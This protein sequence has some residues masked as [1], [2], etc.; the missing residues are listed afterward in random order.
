[1][2]NLIIGFL[3]L[4]PAIGIA[5][6]GVETTRI[7]AAFTYSGD[8]VKIN[9][10]TEKK[11]RTLKG[12]KGQDLKFY[13][14]PGAINYLSSIG[15]EIVGNSTKVSGSVGGFGGNTWGGTSSETTFILCKEVLVS[16]AKELW[17]KVLKGKK[18]SD[19]DFDRIDDIPIEDKE[20]ADE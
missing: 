9:Y 13:S 19:E 16:E 5:Q 14:L 20:V 17:G 12:D 6:N 4:F 7:Y 11:F 3:L 15:W 8:K 18:N 10:G 2:K 1:M